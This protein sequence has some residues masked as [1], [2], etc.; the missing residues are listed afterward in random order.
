MTETKLE[1]ESKYTVGLAPERFTPSAYVLGIFGSYLSEDSR[2]LM[3]QPVTATQLARIHQFYFLKEKGGFTV[4]E[5]PKGY[6]IKRK[7][8]SAD[9]QIQVTNESVK[10]QAQTLNEILD[11]VGEV[12]YHGWLVRDRSTIPRMSI[13]G[14][15]IEF[16]LS[17]DLC[18]GARGSER[19]MEVEYNAS[20]EQVGRVHEIEE[21]IAQILSNFSGR[22]FRYLDSDIQ[23]QGI[24][25]TKRTKWEIARD[26]SG[27]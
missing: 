3:P 19:Q 8:L 25:K 2:I 5:T 16:E 22:S 26:L 6:K 17:L 12:G 21:L 13:Q 1:V 24:E 11:G 14:T 9:A 10:Q 7:S 15:G 23:I 4:M 20:P 27:M 18:M